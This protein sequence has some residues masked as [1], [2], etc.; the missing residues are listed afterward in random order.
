MADNCILDGGRKLGCKGSGGV[1]GS[2]LYL[3]N[4]DDEVEYTTGNTSSLITGVDPS[5]NDAGISLY[6]F[7]QRAQKVDFTQD[8]QDP[9]DGIGIES[10]LTLEFINLDVEL[11]DLLLTLVRAP[12]FGVVKL[13]NG[14][15]ILLGKDMPG[16]VTEGSMGAGINLIDLNGGTLTITWISIDGADFI[17]EDVLNKTGEPDKE[18]IT[19]N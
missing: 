9:T 18:K 5:T 13:N 10:K 19:I 12:L 8:F 15:W 16:E 3:G 17:N 14:E 2:N 1:D 7:V 11:R 4:Y 6:K